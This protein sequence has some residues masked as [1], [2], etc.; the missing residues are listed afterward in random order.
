MRLHRFFGNFNLDKGDIKT[1]DEELVHQ[2]R[3]VLRLEPGNE[4]LLLDGSGREG[5]ASIGALSK[6]HVSFKVLGVRETEAEPKTEITLYMALV[7]RGNFEE[8][9]RNAVQAGVSR[10]API[11]TKWTVKE[12]LK[13][14]RL[15][16][17][18]K[19]SAE[20]S[21]RGRLPVLTEVGGFERAVEDAEDNDLNIFFH[22]GESIL[23]KDSLPDKLPERVGIFVGPEGGWSDEEIGIARNN[24]FIMA[25]LGDLTLRTE[26]AAIV[27]PYLTLYLLN[28]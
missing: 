5:L 8:A 7:K 25:G 16:K 11:E 17:I 27:A 10:I 3:D 1:S 28:N 9:S 23:T 15:G 6:T 13:E 20:Q 14:K 22:K 26:T 4:V 19:E 24:G 21:G 2:L 12:G 18:L